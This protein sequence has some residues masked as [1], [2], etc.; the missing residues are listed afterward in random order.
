MYLKYRVDHFIGPHLR[1]RK[2]TL[3]LFALNDSRSLW[4]KVYD[5]EV[6]Y[7][8]LFVWSFF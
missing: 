4:R 7:G 5:P 3:T 6:G 8:I 1:L 2:E